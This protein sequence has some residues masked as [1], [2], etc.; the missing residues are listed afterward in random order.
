[1]ETIKYTTKVVRG[2]WCE[3]DGQKKLIITEKGFNR[4][5]QISLNDEIVYRSSL[6]H[7]ESNIFRVFKGHEFLVLPNSDDVYVKLINNE[8]EIKSGLNIKELDEKFNTL[9]RDL[10]IEDFESWLAMDKER[11]KSNLD[12]NR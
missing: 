6:H 7:P 9:L 8:I 4:C 3:N 2:Y 5:L 10:T 1:M 12:G 11:S